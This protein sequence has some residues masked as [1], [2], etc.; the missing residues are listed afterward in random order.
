MLVTGLVQ[1]A[2]I[3]SEKAVRIKVVH[4]FVITISSCM[5][6]TSSAHCTVHL[7][8]VE[9]YWS[10]K[11]HIQCTLLWPVQSMRASAIPLNVQVLAVCN[12]QSEI[13]FTSLMYSV[14]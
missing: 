3:M 1:T 11:V 13:K 5:V 12:L 8:T 6:S 14:S 4:G 2:D 7:I 9:K 10:D